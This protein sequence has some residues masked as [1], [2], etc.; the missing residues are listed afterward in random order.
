MSEDKNETMSGQQ[1]MLH[2]LRQLIDGA[3]RWN[4]WRNENRHIKLDFSQQ[5]FEGIFAANL[6]DV[7]F[8]D[9]KFIG[10][11]FRSA[12]LRGANFGYSQLEDA[13][14]AGA[15]LHGANFSGANLIRT[16][17]AGTKGT[18]LSSASSLSGANLTQA[19]VSGDLGGMDL[20]I[21]TC[22][23]TK[24][25]N[26]VLNGANAGEAN[27]KGAIFNN[28][29]LIG[30]NIMGANFSSAEFNN[31]NFTGAHIGLTIFANNDLSNV[32]GLDTLNHRMPSSIGIDTIYKSKG[33]IPEIFLR[34]CG[35]PDEFITYM[36]S[37]TAAGQPI[38]FYSCFISHS[39]KDQRFCDRLFA[40]LQVKGVRTWYFPEDA[41]WGEPVWKEIDQSIKIYDKLVV[42]CS[43]HSLQSGPVLRE[44]ERSLNREDREGKSIL[45]PVRID[46]YIFDEWQHERKDDLL[47]KVIGDFRKWRNPE[48]YQKAFNKLLRDLKAEEK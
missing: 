37:L 28:V 16:N 9:A 43:K 47:R 38:K 14:F 31:I 15:D 19:E 10:A 21:C 3:E 35:V 2:L 7:D 20:T 6:Y 40:D 27:F 12:N 11:N 45:F 46:N 42:V 8:S 26:V 17:L 36:H 32:K 24:F 41:R 5:K 44:I 18:N 1:L 33:K 30:A 48:A 22:K 39:T 25:S 23:G 34:G 4:N 29:T 13:Y